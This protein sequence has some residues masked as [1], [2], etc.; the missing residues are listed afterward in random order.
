MGTFEYNPLVD[1]VMVSYV[2]PNCNNKNNEFIAVP[3]PDLTSETARES[4]S[5]DNI[6]IQCEHCGEEFRIE[7]ATSYNAGWGIM[8]GVEKIVVIE[9]DF[10]CEN[11]EDN[12]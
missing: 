12:D 10:P 5:T 11:E 1:A 4:V 3:S 2:C 7:L 6:D 9:E 8:H